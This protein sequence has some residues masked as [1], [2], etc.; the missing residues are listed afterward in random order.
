MFKDLINDSEQYQLNFIE[1]ILAFFLK[2]LTEGFQQNL[3]SILPYFYRINNSTQRNHVC[4]LTLNV[5]LS[6]VK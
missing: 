3:E 2:L 1:R 4:I 6:L 5:P